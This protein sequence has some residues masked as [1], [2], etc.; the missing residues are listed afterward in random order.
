MV[1]TKPGSFDSGDRQRIQAVNAFL[2]CAVA[3]S[4]GNL[5]H[6]LIFFS[7]SYLS[8]FSNSTFCPFTSVTRY[9]LMNPQW[10]H[11]FLVTY[12]VV[13]HTAF[14][15]GDNDLLTNFL[16]GLCNE[17]PKVDVPIRGDGGDLGVISAMVV[18]VLV[19]V[20]MRRCDWQQLG[21][22]GRGS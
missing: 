11:T 4:E 2:A 22:C 15:D 3:L 10:K 18:M 14:I 19:L 16:H 6:N 13:N 5:S 12:L 21:S 7:L 20:G 9:G 1:N 17:V 8:D